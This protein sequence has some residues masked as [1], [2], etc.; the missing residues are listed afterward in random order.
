[1]I[2]P[3]LASKNKG[4][5]IQQYELVSCCA[6]NLHI[7]DERDGRDAHLNHLHQKPT[8]N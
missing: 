1:M 6:S 2:N 3:S 8:R 7:S 5:L 4:A